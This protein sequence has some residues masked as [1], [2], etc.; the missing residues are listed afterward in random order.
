MSNETQ[1]T[2]SP[3]FGQQHSLMTDMEQRLHSRTMETV[4]N[5]FHRGGSR[6]CRKRLPSKGVR[7]L[8]DGVNLPEV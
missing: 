3:T 5:I 6:K 1:T 7:L 8:R 4:E 2:N